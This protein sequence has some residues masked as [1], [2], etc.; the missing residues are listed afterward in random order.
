MTI[1]NSPYDICYK[2]LIVKQLLIR[3]KF[4]YWFLSLYNILIQNLVNINKN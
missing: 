3:F 1:N 2:V 4:D